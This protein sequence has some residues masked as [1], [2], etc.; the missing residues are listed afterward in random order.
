MATPGIPPSLTILAGDVESTTVTTRLIIPSSARAT[1]PPFMRV[2]ETLANR[3]RTFPVHSHEHQEVLTYV[4]EGFAS[5][6]LEG[7]PADVL[8]PGSARF[9]I[10]PSR[11]THSISPAKGGP[12]RWFSLVITLPSA[13]SG[14]PWLQASETPSSPLYQGDAWVRPLVGATAPMRSEAALECREITFVEQSTTFQ[15]VGH[16]RRGVV[17]ALAGRGAVDGRGLESGEAALVE[18]AAGIAIQGTEN[19]RVIVAT[20]PR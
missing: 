6:S 11:S 15:R 13:V 14:K 9:L 19:L 18:G 20:V 4:S 2:G 10:S 16:D 12:V 17:Y 3:F 8:K 5:Y 1:W 7:H